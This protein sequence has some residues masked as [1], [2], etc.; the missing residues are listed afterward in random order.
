MA[1]K[2]EKF[3]RYRK[4]TFRM[5]ADDKYR[6]LSRP[7]A[8]GQALWW[9]LIAG[10]QT[11]LIP[12]LMKI[13]E[14]AFA[15]QLGWT[16]KGFREAFAEVFAEGMAKADWD[17]RLIWVPNALKHN[18][19]ENPNVVTK[20]R[21]RW[22]FLPECELKLE[23]YL[24][25]ETVL[26]SKGKAFAEAFRKACTKP[27]AKASPKTTP[28]QEAGYRNSLSSLKED[29]HTP[30]SGFVK[31]TIDEIKAYCI[32]RAN[33]IDPAQFFDHYTANGWKVGKVPMKDWQAAVRQWERNQFS[34]NGKGQEPTGPKPLT[35]EE[36]KDLR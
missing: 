2:K 34:S 14:L 1:R 31:P 18:M 21:D 13:G 22:P 19:P 4:I 36:I 7:Q 3:D 24:H 5:H 26:E 23:A 15:E 33:N 35:D 25:I 20:W 32:E 6:R 27:F 12:G 10:E 9:N 30:Q 29:K 11:D 8:C 16:L 17:A 28:N